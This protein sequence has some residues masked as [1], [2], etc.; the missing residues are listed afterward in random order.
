MF[1]LPKLGEGTASSSLS[2]VQVQQQGGVAG[3]EC[4]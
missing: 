4:K 2:I 1:E 3:N